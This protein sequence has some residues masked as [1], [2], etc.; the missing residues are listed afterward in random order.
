M[1]KNGNKK[2]LQYKNT[3]CV[4]SLPDNLYPCANLQK[5]KQKRY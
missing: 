2:S 4:G 5:Q 1:K 3:M